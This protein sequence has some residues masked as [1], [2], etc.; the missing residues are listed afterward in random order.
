MTNQRSNTHG[1]TEW[2]D[3]IQSLLELPEGD[4]VRAVWERHADECTLCK[5]VLESELEIRA[6][7]ERMEYPGAAFISAKVMH[8]IRKKGTGASMF[9]PRDLVY[10][11]VA[12]IAGVFIGF[13]IVAIS[14]AQATQLSPTAALEQIIVDLDEGIDPSMSEFNSV[15]EEDS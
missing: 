13:Q 11:L 5:E 10:G 8:R 7:M 2:Q 3:Q 14:D 15:I 4:E 1:C 6:G 12:S 9:R